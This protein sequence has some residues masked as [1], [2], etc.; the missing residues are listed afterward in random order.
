MSETKICGD[1][2]RLL[3]DA[4]DDDRTGLMI[5]PPAQ[6]LIG[7]LLVGEYGRESHASLNETRALADLLAADQH[8][9]FMIDVGAHHGSALMPFL[10][11][12][13]RVLAFEPDERNRASLVH[14]ICAHTNAHLVTLDPRAVS[15]VSEG[16]VSFFR[17][18][19]GTGMSALASFH[20]SHVPAHTV[21]I[22]S[23]SDALTNRAYREVD[24]LLKIDT[25]GHDLLVLRGFSWDEYS[26]EVIECEFENN[27]TTPPD[28]IFHDLA[29][30]LLDK[31]DMSMLVNCTP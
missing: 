10:T 3:K 11:E 27:K 18:A 12:G 2:H 15:D 25:K 24:D 30:Y 5:P 19:L 1:F 6:P 31:E 26:P 13:W 21:D 22:I 4:F 9:G 14:R 16:D 17:S 8:D 23:L 20:K 28:Y 7:E 29:Q